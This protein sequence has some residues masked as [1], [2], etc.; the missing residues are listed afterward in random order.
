V[1][2]PRRRPTST[3]FCGYEQVRQGGLLFAGE[4]TSIDFQ[5]DMNGGA[6]QGER[7]AK[8]LLFLI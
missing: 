3:C 1:I 4:H 5:G 2:T 8:E 6:E 7:A